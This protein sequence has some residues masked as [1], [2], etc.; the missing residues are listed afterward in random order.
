MSRHL[1]ALDDAIEHRANT[2]PFPILRATAHR[3]FALNAMPGAAMP[4]TEHTTANADGN[5]AVAQILM[6]RMQESGA[7]ERIKEW[8]VEALENDGWTSAMDRQAAQLVSKRAEEESSKDANG[9]AAPPSVADVAQ[10]LFDRGFGG[11][12]LFS[13]FQ[14]MNC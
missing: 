2:V 14:M 1:N 6:E 10:Q 12:M 9:V 5:V 7:R 11:F 13:Y 3:R 8:L 4:D